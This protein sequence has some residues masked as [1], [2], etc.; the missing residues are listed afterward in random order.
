MVHWTKNESCLISRK[1]IG[2]KK[3]SDKRRI[4]LDVIREEREGERERDKIIFA[5]RVLQKANLYKMPQI[6]K[7]KVL[8]D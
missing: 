8:T 7:A 3:L 5:Q 4:Q 1:E 2:R 6:D